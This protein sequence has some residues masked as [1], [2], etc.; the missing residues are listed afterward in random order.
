MRSATNGI[1][2]KDKLP[3]YI[4]ILGDKKIAI[5]GCGAVGSFV[6]EALVKSGFRKLTLIDM[7]RLEE[8]NYAKCSGLYRFP[9]DVG[10]NKAVILAERLNELLQEAWVVG[11]DESVTR[12]GPKSLEGF[13]VI[14]LALDNYAAKL[15][16]NQIWKQI[17]LDSRPLLI[18]GGTKG[19]AAHSNCL[20]GSKFCLRDLIDDSWL[21]NLLVRTSCEGPHYRKETDE[22]E[23]AITTGL[24]S[25][26]CAD[27]ITEQVR[28]YC[29]GEREMINTRVIYSPYPEFKISKYNIVPHKDC[30]DCR[31]YY[32]PAESIAIP[33]MNVK[34]T[35]IRELMEY[36]R[37][38]VDSDNFE[39]LVPQIDFGFITYNQIVKD[40]YC[41]CCASPIKSIYRHEYYTK[42]SEMLCHECKKQGNKA[43]DSSDNDL[44]GEVMNAFTLQDL[45]S[46]WENRTLYDLGFRIGEFIRVT[47]KS[48]GTDIFD[49]CWKE[50]TFY[51]E[52]DHKLMIA[53]EE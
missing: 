39:V 37:A 32:P 11:F 36:I 40:D 19:E 18:S 46:D 15:Y 48:E 17:S 1:F 38:Y 23:F 12:F 20:D 2:N 45:N 24:A 34:K 13:D 33:K 29:L 53:K 41:K 22:S 52:N 47:V 43:N 7:D 50:L 49:E 14:I 28:A 6:A 5:I 51:C 44:V 16:S 10:K 8:D 42:Y 25:R 27:I 26:I 30:P 31:N 21:E 4:P 3:D 9:E 35:T